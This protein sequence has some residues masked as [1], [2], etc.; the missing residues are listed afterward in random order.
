MKIIL[1]IDEVGDVHGLYTDKV[2]LFSIGRIENVK[3]ASNVEFNEQSQTWM[4]LSLD[5][6]VLYQNQNR[7][8]AIQKEIELF[9]PGG[10]F[11]DR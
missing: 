5:S 2:N 8:V 10:K 6:K 7:E 11:Y 1:E 3:K 4:V 9:S